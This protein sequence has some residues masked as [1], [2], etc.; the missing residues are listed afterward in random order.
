MYAWI[1][2]KINKMTTL[3]DESKDQHE[4][5]ITGAIQKLLEEEELEKELNDLIQADSYEVF[6]L[7]YCS[8]LYDT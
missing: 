8:V 5:G 3:M 6:L 7:F 4:S 2:R 1:H